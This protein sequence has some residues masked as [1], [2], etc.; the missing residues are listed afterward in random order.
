MGSLTAGHVRRWQ[1]PVTPPQAPVQSH[2]RAVEPDQP[3]SHE[4]GT[5]DEPAGVIDQELWSELMAEQK[6]CTHG[7][8]IGPNTPAP[9]QE[10]VGEPDQPCSHTPAASVSESV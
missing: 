7:E 3:S 10:R 6:S 4:P 9:E 2:D 1:L 5:F 8:E